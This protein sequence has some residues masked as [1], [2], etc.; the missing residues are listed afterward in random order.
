MR[1]LKLSPRLNERFARTLTLLSVTAACLHCGGEHATIS[2]T[3][4]ALGPTPYEVMPDADTASK[5]ADKCGLAD[6]DLPETGTPTTPTTPIR[7][8]INPADVGTLVSK[9]WRLIQSFASDP[10]ELASSSDKKANLWYKK[11]GGRDWYY[12]YRFQDPDPNVQENFNGVL[13]FDA[14]S[15]CAFDRI[16]KNPSDAPPP[17]IDYLHYAGENETRM[18][19]CSQ[20]HVHGYIAPR[21]KSLAVAKD[22]PGPT[23]NPVK[24]L[25]PW[26]RYAAAFGPQWKLGKAPTNFKW[27]SGQGAAPLTTPASCDGCHDSQW[28][29][30]LNNNYCTSVFEPAFDPTL[31][32][33]M[34]PIGSMLRQGSKF[35][36]AECAPFVAA[37]GCNTAICANAVAL[38]PPLPRVNETTVLVGDIKAIDSTTIQITP[39]QNPANIWVAGTTSAIGD[40]WLASLQVW[41]VPYTGSPT[42]TSPMTGIIS[43]S[44]PGALSP[45]LVTGL[46]PSTQYIFQLNTTDA[47]GSSA[48][49]PTAIISTSPAANDF[50]ISANPSSLTVIQGA[51]DT[52]AIDTAVT[53]GSAQSVSLSISGVPSGASASFTPNPI[54]SGGSSTLTINGGAATP[55]AYTLTVTGTGASATHTTTVTVTVS[56][57]ALAV[58]PSQVTVAVGTSQTFTASGGSGTGYT[59]D[60][61][62]NNSGGA[63]TVAGVYTAGATGGVTDVVRVTDSANHTATATVTVS[64]A[65]ATLAVSP[66]QVTVAVGASQTFTA[67]GGSGTGYAWD[68]AT[69]NSG[70]AITAAGIYTAGATG[71]VT[72]VVR[73]TDSASHTA[74]ATVTVTASS[75]PSDSNSGCST[76]GA[77][78]P[79]LAFLVLLLLFSRRRRVTA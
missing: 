75:V 13:G 79:Q 32:S 37:L 18:D 62:T 74:T 22:G 49:S 38:G 67:S 24:W 44:N 57:A 27:V 56:V 17:S 50:S 7:G 69:N 29:K 63:I 4:Q 78:F 59:W 2:T 48:F 39:T 58:S 8:T 31:D 72:D 1:T 65:T 21:E 54:T 51:S 28:I 20:C 30:P 41:G 53:S 73:V 45:I 52:S 64:M 3:S 23:K 36:A 35:T 25:L 10:K 77:R 61:A 46:S 14:T 34:K 33:S 60:L 9:G 5:Y 68:L 16:L 76:T 26:K 19:D 43:I 12:L 47:D 71:G 70:G 66:S 40:P 55:N 42:S 6:H 15:I 11:A